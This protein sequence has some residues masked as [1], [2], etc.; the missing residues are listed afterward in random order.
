MLEDA[1]A[2]IPQMRAVRGARIDEEIRGISARLAGGTARA[3][4][5]AH[6]PRGEF[7]HR[8][9]RRRMKSCAFPTTN[10]NH[11][12]HFRYHERPG[13]AAPRQTRSLR[14]TAAANAQTSGPITATLSSH[15]RRVEGLEGPRRSVERP[16]AATSRVTAAKAF[17]PAVPIKPRAALRQGDRGAP[18]VVLRRR[19]LGPR[20]AR[21]TWR[22]SA[23]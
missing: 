11:E 10:P 12:N 23:S 18:R 22:A 8:A 14:R 15:A 20:R 5:K 3:H 7:C 16:V 9:W 4:F 6:E 21:A 13:P 1:V 2:E 17:P 19:C